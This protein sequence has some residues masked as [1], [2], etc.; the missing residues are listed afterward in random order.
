[1]E[2]KPYLNSCIENKDIEEFSIAWQLLGG[3]EANKETLLY[4]SGNL[5][6]VTDETSLFY[7]HTFFCDEDYIGKIDWAKVTTLDEANR[8]V[9]KDGLTATCFTFYKDMLVE[10]SAAAALTEQATSVE[11]YQPFSKYSQLPGNLKDI[12]I[13]DDTYYQVMQVLGL[14]FV[15]ES[16]LEYN[17]QAILKLAFEPALRMYYTYFPIVQEQV[18]PSQAGTDIKIKYP[19]IPYEAYQAITWVTNRTGLG[20]RGMYGL[21]PLSLATLGAEYTSMSLANDRFN[22]GLPYNK[23]VPGFTGLA[24]T[25]GGSSMSMAGQNWVLANT[26]RNI[27]RREKFSKTHIP[28]EGL[29][30][31]GYSTLTGYLN[32]KWLCWS[33]DFNDVQFEDWNQVIALCQAFVKVSIGSIRELLRTDSN[34]PFKD[35]ITKEGQ[36]EI[37]AI[38]DRWKES[39]S[40]LIYSTMRGGYL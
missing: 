17:R 1:M 29:Y 37:K 22:G 32:I 3:K 8:T 12:V 24:V 34:L 23:P 10:P 27:M 30:L 36:D 2:I 6:T 35:G 11:G 7:H 26:M 20:T 13:D 18:L 25:D 16:E 5:Y 19:T 33:R 21:S 40:R 15:N 4:K 28:G 39:P 9:L 31:T 14:P 38:E